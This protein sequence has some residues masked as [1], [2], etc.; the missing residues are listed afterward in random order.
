MSI[1]ALSLAAALAVAP[2]IAGETSPG[3]DASSRVT[4]SVV[5]AGEAGPDGRSWVEH[6]V[7]PGEA[8]LEHLAVRNFSDTAVAFRL[9]AADGY[10]TSTGRF[11]MLPADERSVDAGAWIN[12]QDEVTV[13][14]GAEALVPFTV[15]V[16]TNATPGDHAAGI[17]ASVLSTGQAESG[18]SVGVESRVGFRVML[19]VTGELVPSVSVSGLDI[20]YEQSWNPFQPGDLNVHYDAINDG[21][22][23]LEV[24]RSID[25]SGRFSTDAGPPPTQIELL[26]GDT[27]AATVRVAEVWPLGLNRVVVEVTATAIPDGA[28]APPIQREVWVWAVP[29]PQLIT[30]AALA[31]LVLGLAWGRRRRKAEL[32]RLIDDA[33]RDGAAEAR[34]SAPTATA[35]AAAQAEDAR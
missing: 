21:N 14:P 17:A 33:R 28:A 29:L 2:A 26:P 8:L 25:A 34:V 23:R 10:I 30:L 22:A 5:P 31:L 27:R 1:L 16:P 11:N 35:A 24:S 13:Q 12:V 6:E 4:W 9:S 15:A 7:D 18:T 3:D 32:A 20:S 19:R